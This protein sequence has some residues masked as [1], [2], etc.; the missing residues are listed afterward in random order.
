LRIG[1][2]SDE[3]GSAQANERLLALIGLAPVSVDEMIRQSGMDAGAVQMAL[4]ELELAGAIIR[5][6]GARISRAV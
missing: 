4:I 6:A 1:P 2:D 5:H 3:D